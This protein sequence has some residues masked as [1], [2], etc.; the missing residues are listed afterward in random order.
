MSHRGSRTTVLRATLA[1]PRA[2]LA[3]LLLALA[4]LVPQLLT[5]PGVV[6]A[7]TKTYLFLEPAR[8]LRQ[9]LSMWD[10]TVGLG[11]VT[12]LQIGYLFPMGPF[13]WATHALRLP[14]WA[15]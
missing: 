15:A 11:T 6:D 12:H 8:Y 13:F 4:A 3:H 1:Q 9:S 2:R 10:P 7:D 5:R 14:T